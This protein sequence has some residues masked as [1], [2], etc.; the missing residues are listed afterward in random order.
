[1]RRVLALA[2]TLTLWLALPAAAGGP[3]NVVR[4]S[5]TADGSHIH[6]ASVKVLYDRCRCRRLEQRRVGDA[7]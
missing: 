6:R 2:T 3:N 4:V 7:A 1:M 5:P